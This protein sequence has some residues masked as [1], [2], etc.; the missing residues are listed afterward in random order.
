M[1]PEWN[2]KCTKTTFKR[3][4][5]TQT[6]SIHIDNNKTTTKEVEQEES[7]KYRGIYEGDG[8]QHAKMKMIRK[9]YYRR[10]RL[11]VKSEQIMLIEW[12]VLSP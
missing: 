7:Y 12:K 5:L 9:E 4:E 2:A 10:I 8:V 3:G 1:T 11:V 6:I